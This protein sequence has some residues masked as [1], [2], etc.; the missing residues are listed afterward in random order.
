M[1]WLHKKGKGEQQKMQQNGQVKI[2]SGKALSDLAIRRSLII[3]PPGASVSILVKLNRKITSEATYSPRFPHPGCLFLSC[4][5]VR[6][7][8][9]LP[10]SHSQPEIQTSSPASSSLLSASHKVPFNLSLLIKTPSAHQA[11]DSILLLPFLMP[12]LGR[13]TSAMFPNPVDLL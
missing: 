1:H 11:P 6:K 3:Q 4:R 2:R 7:I 10:H 5:S 8:S 12:H 9:R 13:V